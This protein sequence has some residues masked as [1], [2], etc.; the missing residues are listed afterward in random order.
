MED[1]ETLFEDLRIAEEAALSKAR[2]DFLHDELKFRLPILCGQTNGLNMH[3]TWYV[4]GMPQ[5]ALMWQGNIGLSLAPKS[6]ASGFILTR[7]WHTMGSTSITAV[8]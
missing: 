2:M 4:G 6:V 7:Y 8:R 1:T 3:R 5:L